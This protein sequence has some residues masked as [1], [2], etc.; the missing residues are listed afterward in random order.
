MSVNVAAQLVRIHVNREAYQ[1]PNPTTGEALYVL[2][3][4][5]KHEKLYREVDGDKEDKVVPRDDAQVH[6]TEDEHFYS[7]KS[8]RHPRQRR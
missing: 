5:P 2:G 6:L 1:S 4:I 3:D 7:Q 8:V